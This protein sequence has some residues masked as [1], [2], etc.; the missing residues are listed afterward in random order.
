MK[1]KSFSFL[2]LSFVFA[3]CTFY[4]EYKMND[5]IEK[6]TQIENAISTDFQSNIN[7][8]SNGLNFAN[9]VCQKDYKK[10]NEVGLELKINTMTILVDS[11][12]IQ[13]NRFEAITTSFVNSENLTSS[14]DYDDILNQIEIYITNYP[15]CSRITEILN[16]RD[17]ILF[18]KFWIVSKLEIAGSAISSYAYDLLIPTL[19]DY[20]V[21]IR[22]E[23]YRKEISD[24]IREI[25][26]ENFNSKYQIL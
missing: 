15:N 19:E 26:E 14:T 7:S 20:L 10:C 25:K 23:Q 18:K 22:K 5:E 13:K 9:E 11:F 3:K 6:L 16:V 4:Y 21:K 1:F 8:I 24:K 12:Q 2:V 17:E